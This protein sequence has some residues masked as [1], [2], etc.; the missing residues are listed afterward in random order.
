M[1]RLRLLLL[2]LLVLLSFTMFSREVKRGAM[3]NL[4]FAVTV[5]VQE[6]IDNSSRLRL[7]SITGE[8]MEGSSFLAS[9]LFSIMVITVITIITLIKRKKWR[10]AALL[11]PLAFGLMTIAEIYGKSIVHHPAPPFFLLKNPT[12]VFPKYYVWEDYSYPSGHAARAMFLAIVLF[13]TMKKRVW[14]M[15]SLILLVILISISRIYLGHHW[16]SDVIGGLILGSG[17]GLLT[18]AFLLSY[19]RG[20]HE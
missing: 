14:I 19:N 2:G 9:P 17:S 10:I 7:A 16:L 13:F 3:R 20:R 15:F 1:K 6:R 5:K 8:I 18:T 12:T 11:I 4:D